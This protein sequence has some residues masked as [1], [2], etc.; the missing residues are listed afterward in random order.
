MALI[1]DT[2]MT[3]IL[4]DLSQ[5]PVAQLTTLLEGSMLADNGSGYAVAL[6][7]GLAFRGHSVEHC[8]NSTG[9]NGAVAVKRLRGRYRLEVTLTGVLITDVGKE[10]YASADDT[11]TL[12]PGTANSR[13]G[14]IDRYV[15][16]D[17]CIVEFQ[18]V[19]VPDLVLAN[20]ARGRASTAMPT[21]AIWNNFNLVEMRNNPLA[22]SLIEIDFT[23]GENEPSEQFADATGLVRCIPGVAGEGALT[24]YINAD[25][26]ATEIQFPTC[27]IISTGGAPWALEA[28][29]KVSQIVDTKAGW[30]I[31]LMA[32]DAALAGDL[33]ADAGTLANVGCI[34]FQNKEGDGDILDAVYDN[35]AQAQNEHDDDWHTLVADAYL[36]VGLHYNGTTITLYKNGV[37]FGDA[38]A[39]A[40]IAAVDFPAAD[41]LVPTLCMKGAGATPGVTVTLDWIRCAQLAA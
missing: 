18:T 39:A 28:R 9:G 13:V 30:F 4:G 17:T 20:S 26:E 7:A 1:V 32:G 25:N 40:D 3:R 41:I 22:G 19:E 2:P 27:P 21:D 37:A 14:V 5:L 36:T 34:G 16:T 10:V 8:D 38:I 33:I 6:T 24:T 11:Y 29:V 35:A 23:H 15:T 12:S 31:G